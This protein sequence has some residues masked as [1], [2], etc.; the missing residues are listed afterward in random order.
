MRVQHLGRRVGA[1]DGLGRVAGHGEGEQERDA[2]SRRRAPRPSRAA[3]GRGTYPC[4]P[5]ARP[6]RRPARRPAC[7]PARCPSPVCQPLSWC[8]LGLLVWYT[9]RRRPAA[10]RAQVAAHSSSSRCS[11]WPDRMDVEATHVGPVHGVGD[12]WNIGSTAASS[13]MICCILVKSRCGP[14]QGAWPR[15]RSNIV[16]TCGFHQL[17]E[18]MPPSTVLALLNSGPIQSLGSGK[19]W[20]QSVPPTSYW[21]AP[22]CVVRR[23]SSA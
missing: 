23:S 15:P 21:P 11:Y 12:N 2:G 18:F 6:R 9:G 3:G 17:P 19:S 16:S 20:N 22:L 14:G 8:C 5:P 10:A 7:R 1:G 13:M 4:S